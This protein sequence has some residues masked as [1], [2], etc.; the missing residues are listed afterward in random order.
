[1]FYIKLENNSPVNHP[2][3]GDNLKNILDAA[4]ITED[5]L[6][7]H[8]YARFEQT[9]VPTEFVYVTRKAEYF[10][11]TDGVVRDK[12]EVTPFTQKEIIDVLIRKPRSFMLAAC[13]WTQSAD[14][15]LSPEKKQEWAEYRAA[16]RDLTNKYPT[17]QSAQ[18]IEW[19]AIPE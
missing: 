13:D 14:S 12:V 11:D 15:P 4:V 10:L 16:L 7:Y 5:L 17:V 3:T 19:P 8:G 9:T 18:E 6:K 1:M 2:M